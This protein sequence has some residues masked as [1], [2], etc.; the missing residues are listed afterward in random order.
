MTLMLMV[1]HLCTWRSRKVEEVS[2]NFL[3]IYDALVA[4]IN[5]NK[6]NK[7]KTPFNLN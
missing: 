1:G 3:G 6:E 4:A 2:I 5:Y 7:L